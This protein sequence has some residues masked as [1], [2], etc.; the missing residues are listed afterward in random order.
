MA[1]YSS[2]PSLRDAGVHHPVEIVGGPAADAGVVVGRDVGHVQVAERRRHRAGRRRTR[3]PPGAVWQ[4]T[5]SPA[6][7]R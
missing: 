7:A 1:G 4:A 6:R 2:V 3:V 5:Q